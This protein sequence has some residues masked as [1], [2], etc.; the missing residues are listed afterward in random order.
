MRVP[1]ELQK[2]R[3]SDCRLT[4]DRA[5]ETLDDAEAFLHDRGLLTRSP[6]CS[7]PS[8]FGACHE[9]PYKPGA[10]GFGEWPRTKW[11]WSFELAQLPGVLAPKI[12]QGKTLYLSP[13]AVRL[14]DPIVRAEL[15]RMTA[16]DGEWARL[17]AH[18]AEAGPSSPED[19]QTELGLR[20]QDLK[21]L[22]A[23]LERCGVLV[24]RFERVAGEFESRLYRWD[25]LAPEPAGEAPDLAPLVVAAVRATVIVPEREPERWFSWRWRWEDGLVDRLVE[26]GALACPAPGWL[27][28][29]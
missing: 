10:G 16:A 22:R 19:L 7:L 13:E 11:S 2:R 4:P 29:P 18:L 20:R 24:T 1:E 8:L 6:D 9:E 26:E 25:Q 15:D 3:A 5:L 14:V 17:L 28:A 21:K 12:H 23:P 27:C